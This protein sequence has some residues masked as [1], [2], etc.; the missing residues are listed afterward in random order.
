[1]ASR[2]RELLAM[3]FILVLLV[4]VV[5]GSQVQAD[6]GAAVPIN[7]RLLAFSSYIGPVV[8]LTFDDPAVLRVMQVMH[9][10]SLR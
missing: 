6:E 4:I 9:P 3:S 1:M 2:H 10:G 8:N 5:W 7:P